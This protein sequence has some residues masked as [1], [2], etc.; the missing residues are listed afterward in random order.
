MAILLREL[1]SHISD[2]VNSRLYSGPLLPPSD[3]ATTGSADANL[4]RLIRD[5]HYA[6]P[7]MAVAQITKE[8]S[9]K[10]LGGFFK[11]PL[12]VYKFN[13][14]I[15]IFYSG[16]YNIYSSLGATK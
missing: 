3:V 8:R 12:F 13:Y 14:T 9:N 4:R 10:F 15:D 16:E 5:P 6:D 11:N 7:H 1:A 2:V